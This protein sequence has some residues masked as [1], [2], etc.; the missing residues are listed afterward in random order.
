MTIK[1]NSRTFLKD[2][3]GG[4]NHGRSGDSGQTELLF[5]LLTF[6]LLSLMTLFSY[7]MILYYQKGQQRENAYLC[8]KEN[9]ETH[10]SAKEKVQYANHGIS[11][12][13]AT[14]VGTLGSTA[15]QV[16]Q[17]VSA[18]KKLQFYVVL[19]SFYD[20]YNNDHCSLEQKLILIS[21]TPIRMT[22][23]PLN[24]KRIAGTLARFKFKKKRFF[25]PSQSIK[26]SDFF[27]KGEVHYR[28]GL[29]LKRTK[30]YSLELL[31]P[32]SRSEMKAIARSTFADF[33]SLFSSPKKI[34]EGLLELA[35]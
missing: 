7:R 11:A 27:I 9:I 20:I 6:C 8:L 15:A 16:K 18:L 17:A 32:I 4:A 13:L 29:K 21:L 5:I 24:I 19:K 2:L 10:I 25:F 14:L 22:W 34:I 12:A 1:Q 35:L 26:Q 28:S 31:D 30:E 33:K 3:L 23:A